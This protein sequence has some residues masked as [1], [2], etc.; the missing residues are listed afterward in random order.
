MNSL[1]LVLS[2]DGN[3]G[4]GKSFLLSQIATAFPDVEVVP[5]PVDYDEP[6]GG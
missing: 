2:L 3:V 1:P 6:D 4:A 5:E